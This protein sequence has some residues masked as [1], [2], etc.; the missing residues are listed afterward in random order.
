M[1]GKN[2]NC[3]LALLASQRYLS[4]ADWKEVI[5]YLREEWQ[6]GNCLSLVSLQQKFFKVEAYARL[7][8]ARLCFY[9]PSMG[10]RVPLLYHFTGKL[11]FRPHVSQSHFCSCFHFLFTVQIYLLQ[12]FIRFVVNICSIC[13]YISTHRNYYIG[14]QLLLVNRNHSHL[15]TI[16]TIQVHLINVEYHQIVKERKK[17][18]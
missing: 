14:F 1:E 5:L 7:H 10:R 17:M 3:N 13:V 9:Q 2:L 8:R 12:A 6:G 4:P 11:N 18:Q 15:G 16:H